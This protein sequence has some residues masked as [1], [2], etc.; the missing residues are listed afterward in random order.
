MTLDPYSP[1]ALSYL[2]ITNL[3]VRL[4]KSQTCSPALTPP[5][6]WTSFTSSVRTPPSSSENSAS[7]P[8]AIYTLLARGTC[9]CHG[10]AEDCVPHNNGNKEIEDSNMVSVLSCMYVCLYQKEKIKH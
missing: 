2:T 9:L 6:R 4:L 7:A 5:G 8:Y 3:R 1:E 10:H